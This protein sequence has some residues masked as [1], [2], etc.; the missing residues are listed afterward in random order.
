MDGQHW[1]RLGNYGVRENHFGW[2][3][4]KE[5]VTDSR[6]EGCRRVFKNDRPASFVIGRARFNPEP[7]YVNS[8]ILPDCDCDLPIPHV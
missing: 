1:R 8:R 6:F 3:R 2:S 7:H 5:A 4:P